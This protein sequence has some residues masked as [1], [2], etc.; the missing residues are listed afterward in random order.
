MKININFAWCTN[1]LEDLKCRN[2]NTEN[3]TI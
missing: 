1:A 3:G 2:L